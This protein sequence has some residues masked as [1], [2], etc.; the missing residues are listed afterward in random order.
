MAQA[1][2]LGDTANDLVNHAL[3]IG[4][5]D[6]VSVVLVALDHTGCDSIAVTAAGGSGG[7]GGLPDDMMQQLSIAEL[8]RQLD[9]RSIDYS[10]CVEKEDLIATLKTGSP[11]PMP[12]RTTSSSQARCPVDI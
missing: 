10:G 12:P 5:T 2:P 1:K 4:S 3:Q 7:D 11:P 9:E 8:K 6:N